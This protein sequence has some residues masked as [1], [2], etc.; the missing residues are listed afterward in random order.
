MFAIGDLTETILCD[1]HAVQTIFGKQFFQFFTGCPIKFCICIIIRIIDKWKRYYIKSRVKCGIDQVGMHGNLY[2]V[3]IHQCL[4]SF[5]LIS[6]CQLVG[7]INIDFDLA[8]G[9]FFHQFTELTAT[10]CPG[11]CL[12]C[13]AGKVPGHLRPV[14]VTVIFN[15][16]KGIVVISGIFRSSTSCIRCSLLSRVRTIFCKSFRKCC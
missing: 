6:V 5:R 8:S 11:T 4:D 14:K 16:V 12:R 1:T 2:R 10:I 7:S 9:S 3:S 15:C 13:G